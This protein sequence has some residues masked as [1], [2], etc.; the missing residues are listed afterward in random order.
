MAKIGENEKSV[1]L[2][3]E[4]SKNVKNLRPRRLQ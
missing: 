4:M 2:S 1:L 3:H